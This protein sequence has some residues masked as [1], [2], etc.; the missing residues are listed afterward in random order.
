[1]HVVCVRGSPKIRETL[2][3][4]AA[5][6]KCWKYSKAVIHALILLFFSSTVEKYS[7]SWWMM[8]DEFNFTLEA[9]ACS[10][11]LASICVTHDV[12]PKFIGLQS[13]QTVNYWTEMRSNQSDASHLSFP[14]RS[15]VLS[16]HRLQN[17]YECSQN[18]AWI[19]I[20]NFSELNH[21]TVYYRLS[22]ILYLYISGKFGSWAKKKQWKIKKKNEAFIVN[23]FFFHGNLFIV[24]RT[25]TMRCNMPA[26][27]LSLASIYLFS[28]GLLHTCV[29]FIIIIF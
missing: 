6:A 28:F 29:E 18:T 24:A 12:Q 17:C 25:R 16:I 11:Q 21:R 23:A 15:L 1:M 22:C 8:N 5:H 19:S 3:W 9:N 2:G 13:M 26:P 4:N 14:S 10:G 7:M 20:N 27:A